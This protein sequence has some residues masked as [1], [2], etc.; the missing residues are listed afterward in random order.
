[1]R[2]MRSLVAMSVAATG[3]FS[4]ALTGEA[5]ADWPEKP[6]TIFVHSGAGSSTDLMARAFAKAAEEVTGQSFVVEVKG[7]ETMPALHRA[8]ADGYT[9][10]TQT[11]AFLGE[12]AMGAGFYKP[13]DFQWVARLVGEVPVF[14]VRADSPYQTFGDLVAAGKANPGTISLATYTAG[15]TVWA[16]SMKVAKAADVSFNIIPFGSSGE[17][18]VA[19]LGGNADLAATYPSQMVQAVEAKKA[20]V[21]VVAGEEQLPLLP[22]SPTLKELGFDVVLSHWRGLIGRQGIPED[23][24]AQI[25]AVTK[26]TVETETFKEWAK[27]AGVDISYLDHKEAQTRAESEY[28]DITKSFKDAG[29]IQ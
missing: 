17:T 21:L 11:R 23:V 28:Q 20:R 2:L 1:M 24:L 9:L 16:D 29:L 6:V 10:A 7:K 25:D 27:L 13:E 4:L 19:M 22:G 14:A 26:K 15:S 3:L 8:P 5:L 12:L 18:V